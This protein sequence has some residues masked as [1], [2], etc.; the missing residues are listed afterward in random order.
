MEG[1]AYVVHPVVVISHELDDGEDVV[2]GLVQRVEDLVAGDQDVGRAADS[3]LDLDEPQSASAWHPHMRER[4]TEAANSGTIELEEA[5]DLEMTDVVL[6]GRVPQGGARYVIIE[7]SITVQRSDVLTAKK[8]AAVLQKVSGVM[9]IPAVVGVLITEEAVEAA[10][11]RRRAVH[12]V[13]P[14]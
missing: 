5:D 2:I 11:R 8:R 9:T 3:P 4:N 6:S 7:A 14:G 1:L 12:P 13:Q 10:P